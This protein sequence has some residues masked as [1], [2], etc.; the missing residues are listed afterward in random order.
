[1][2]SKLLRFMIHAVIEARGAKCP[3]CGSTNTDKENGIWV[4]HECGKEW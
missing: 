3:K 4:C 1:V 2:L